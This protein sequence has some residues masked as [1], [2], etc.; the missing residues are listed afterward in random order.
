MLVVKVA[1]FVCTFRRRLASPKTVRTLSFR[2][3]VFNA[4]ERPQQ[5]TWKRS[6]SQLNANSLCLRSET[7]LS[8]E[9]A[10]PESSHLSR[11]NVSLTTFLTDF[12]RATITQPSF[13]I[14]INFA[15]P[16]Y[17]LRKR[18]CNSSS[19]FSLQIFKHVHASP[20]QHR[21]FPPFDKSLSHQRSYRR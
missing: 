21:S 15:S 19:L 16:S 7:L 13:S 12:S 2:A 6:C 20:S 1:K 8:I 3:I 5:T 9:I 14:I 18:V 4:G 10:R 17:T 11:V